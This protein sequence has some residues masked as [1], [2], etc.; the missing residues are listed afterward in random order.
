MGA[1]FLQL[2]NEC[3]DKIKIAEEVFHKKGLILNKKI[4][5]KD[6]ALLVYYKKYFKNENIF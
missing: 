3:S 6:F 4:D 2:K 5:H 1:F